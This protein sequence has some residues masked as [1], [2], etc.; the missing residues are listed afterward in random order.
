MKDDFIVL[1]E[2]A[3]SSNFLIK[4]SFDFNAEAFR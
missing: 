4:K 3:E 1:T 2:Y